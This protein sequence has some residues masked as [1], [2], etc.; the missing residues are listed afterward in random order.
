MMNEQ[1]MNDDE[2]E[3]IMQDMDPAIIQCNTCDCF[4]DTDIYDNCPVCGNSTQ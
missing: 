1:M 2:L 4:V 3:V